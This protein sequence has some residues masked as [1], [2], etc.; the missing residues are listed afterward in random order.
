MI[1]EFIGVTIYVGITV[2][3]MKICEN[4]EIFLPVL[5]RPFLHPTYIA[6]I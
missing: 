4:N 1:L 2:G 6:R 5:E 3:L